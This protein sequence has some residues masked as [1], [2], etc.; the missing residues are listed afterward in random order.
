MIRKWLSLSALVILAG[1]LWISSA[2]QGDMGQ[3]RVRAGA[4]FPSHDTLRASTKTW[5]AAGVVYDMPGYAFMGSSG[6]AISLDF[7]ST[8]ARGARGTI[9]PILVNQNYAQ[10]SAA[11]FT[12]TLSFGIGVYVVDVTGV[13]KSLFGGRVGLN[14]GINETFSLDIQYDLTDRIQSGSNARANGFSA[15]LSYRF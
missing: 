8:N 15:M 3:L 5:F 7:F 2:A 10:T 4:Y 11:G 13:S 12:T 6:T 14:F 1:G 9:V